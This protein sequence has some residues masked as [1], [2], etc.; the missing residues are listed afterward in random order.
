[1][2][3]IIEN[4]WTFLK[5]NYIF[6][7]IFLVFFVAIGYFV[8]RKYMKSPEFD[9]Q[10]EMK[11]AA[12]TKVRGGRGAGSGGSGADDESINKK[13]DENVDIMMFTVDWCPHCKTAL[14]EWERFCSVY[15]GENGKKVNGTKINCIRYDCTNDENPETEEL[16]SKYGIEGFPTIKLRRENG[17]IIEYDAKVKYP[18]L[19][20][21][22][23]TVL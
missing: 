16:L 9:E 14:P 7:A 15:G 22:V 4:A 23:Q 5:T 20:Q 12:S 6:I 3:S 8:Y 2:S 21:F 17:D 19:E 1:M 11:N 13:H 18:I 10:N